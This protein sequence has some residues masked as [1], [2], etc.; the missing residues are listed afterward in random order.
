[1]SVNLYVVQTFELERN[2][3]RLDQERTFKT[4]AEAVAAVKRLAITGV[5]SMATQ[6]Y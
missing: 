5:G 3:L 6:R 2:R 1:M 4:E